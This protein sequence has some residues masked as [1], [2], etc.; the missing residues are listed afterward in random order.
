[1]RGISVNYKDFDPE[2]EFDTVT[3]E[4]YEY[5]CARDDGICQRYGCPGGVLHH[6]KYKGQGG[7]NK[8]SNLIVLS[9]NAHVGK[10]GE[11]SIP[12]DVNYYYSRVK[13][14]EKR[15]RNNLI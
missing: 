15:F 12:L 9:S 3:D 1:M 7:K 10:E 5:V 11:H 13:R 6:I 8:A 4:L 2:E 14:N